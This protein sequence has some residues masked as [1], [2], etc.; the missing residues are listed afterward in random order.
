VL[1]D[2]R[3]RDDRI[4]GAGSCGHYFCMPNRERMKPPTR[5]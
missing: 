2:E 1:C 5:D 3:W 4:A